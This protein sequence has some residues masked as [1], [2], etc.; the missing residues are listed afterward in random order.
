MRAEIAGVGNRTELPAMLR[1]YCLSRPFS[2]IGSNPMS[3]GLGKS[4]RIMLMA[5]NAGRLRH[6][7]GNV[8]LLR[9][10]RGNGTLPCP[11]V[12]DMRVRILR[13]RASRSLGHHLRAKLRSILQ[14]VIN[15]INGFGRFRR[16]PYVGR[17]CNKYSVGGL[18]IEIHPRIAQR[19][20]VRAFFIRAEINMPEDTGAVR[21]TVIL[22]GHV[23]NRRVGRLRRIPVPPIPCRQRDCNVCVTNVC[24]ARSLSFRKYSS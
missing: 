4:H 3:V 24:R 20:A 22:M 14:P 21:T 23:Q 13:G 1:G 16:S 2:R 11:D 15:V 18:G 12:R 10:H 5:S 7:S 9:R 6:H 8:G 19:A 17:F